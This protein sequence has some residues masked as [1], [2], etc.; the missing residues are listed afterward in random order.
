[1]NLADATSLFASTMKPEADPI[2]AAPTPGQ[3]E[4]TTP[5]AGDV[6][7]NGVV[8]AQD[9][10]ALLSHLF[11]GTNP[12]GLANADVNGDGMV[13]LADAT[14]LFGDGAPEN[15]AVAGTPVAPNYQ[16]SRAQQSYAR[17]LGLLA[18]L[19]RNP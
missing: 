6:D 5:L 15:T 8:D 2:A 3:P 19:S 13:N 1:M 18:A 10:K 11:N 14:T 17:S 9:G 12:E 4:P 16:Q 7:G